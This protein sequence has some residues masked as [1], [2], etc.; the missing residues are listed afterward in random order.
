MLFCWKTM[1]SEKPDKMP[2]VT[3]NAVNGGAE[4]LKEAFLSPK[5]DSLAILPVGHFFRT[6]SWTKFHF[7]E[8]L[9]NYF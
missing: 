2:K 8:T 3:V 4:N 5:S 6:C 9:E 1:A 7:R